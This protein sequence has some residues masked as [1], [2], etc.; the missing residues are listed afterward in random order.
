MGAEAGQGALEVLLRL[1]LKSLRKAWRF[2]R[3]CSLSRPGAG[4]HV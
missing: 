1:S 3:R 2:A 4:R